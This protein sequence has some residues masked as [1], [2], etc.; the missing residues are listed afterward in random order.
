MIKTAVAK[1]LTLKVAAVAIAVT[2]AGGVALAA[3]NGA[4]PTPFGGNG[5]KPA[6]THAS[7]KPAKTTEAGARGNASPSPSLVGLCHAYTAGVNDNPGK[8]LENPAFTAL[9]NAAG[10]KDEV[11]DFCAKILAD[12]S[13]SVHPSGAP[14][15]KPSRPAHPTG[16]P[17]PEPN[18]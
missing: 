1:L 16:P 6:A 14:E 4:L 10:G 18:R 7:A 15:N 2:A 5:D 8:A 9:I 11:A 13:A 12:K 17:T 3:G